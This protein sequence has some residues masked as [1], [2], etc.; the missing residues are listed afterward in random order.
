ME[1]KRTMGTRKG[2][3]SKKNQKPIASHRQEKRESTNLKTP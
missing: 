2:T 1:K 3:D